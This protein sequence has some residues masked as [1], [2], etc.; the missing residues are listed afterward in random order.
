[1]SGQAQPARKLRIAVLNRHFGYR[2]GGAE[3][4][5]AAVVEE[6]AARHEIHVFAQEIEH[7]FPGVT[8][9]RIS[10][11]MAKPRWLN[12][13]WFAF[14]T[15]RQTRHGFDAVHSHENTWH[16]D[17]QTVHV[18]P[19][20]LGLFHNRSGLRRALKWV[21]LFTSPRL[22]AYWWLEAARFSPRPGRQVIATSG[23][24]MADTVQAYPHTAACMHVIAPGV[25]VP[26]TPPDRNLA[27]A[28][29]GLPQ[30][31][32]LALFVGN[33]YAKKG[34]G[35]LL[36]ALP[37]VPDLHLAVVGNSQHKAS[38]ER[39]AQQLQVAERVHFVGSLADVTP[40]YAAA[41][42]LV[43]PTTEDTYAM[44]VLEAMAHGLP[45]I[46]SSAPYC[47]IAAE[48]LHKQQALILDDPRDAQALGHALQRLMSCPQLQERLRAAGRQF[49]GE[50]SWR[51]V[52]EQHNA[53]LLQTAG[54][55]HPHHPS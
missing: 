25:K 14:E 46:V 30:D 29:L 38:F 18:R 26:D 23:Q 1:M 39:Q 55:P 52:A 47:G 49:A 11:P 41:D 31:V 21:S 54:K 42:L 40:A 13:L 20:R 15:W 43:H 50:R 32:A 17:L 3:R 8:Y 45:V 35:T 2:F 9:H 36:E 7:D 19:F 28:Q 5:A 53:L 48:L 4:Y 44:V 10:R 12:Q 16:G 27:R 24:V 22:L 33:D 37:Q 6:L 51:A 34:L